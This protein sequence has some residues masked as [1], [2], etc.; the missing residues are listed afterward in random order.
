V[1]ASLLPANY[2]AR[3]C[4]GMA[5]SRELRF[6]ECDDSR[7]IGESTSCDIVLQGYGVEKSHCRMTLGATEVYLEDDSLSGMMVSFDGGDA[8]LYMVR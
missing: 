8:L 7:T 1:V 3:I 2:L 5:S 6:S 4:F